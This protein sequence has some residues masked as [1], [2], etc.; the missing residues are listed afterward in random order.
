[1]A[2]HCSQPIHKTPISI[3]GSCIQA[4]PVLHV[5][6]AVDISPHYDDHNRNALIEWCSILPLNQAEV[7]ISHITQQNRV[8]TVTA[9]YCHT[10]H[11]KRV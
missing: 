3:N 6:D 10:Q 7:K 9:S 4:L 8:F 2:V 1:M 11:Q 5:P